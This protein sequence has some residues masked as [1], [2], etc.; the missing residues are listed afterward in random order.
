MWLAII[1]AFA[2]ILVN[3][4]MDE[5]D[6]RFDRWFN[7]VIKPNS[8]LWHWACPTVSWANKY[9]KNN[10]LRYLLSGPLVFVTDLW[11][12]LKSIFLNLIFLICLIIGGYKGNFLG[13]LGILALINIAWG[14]LFES[15]A[16]VYG[17]LSDKYI[18]TK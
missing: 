6:F 8:K 18:N 12:L 15:F 9:V 17:A 14:I 13:T 11:H 1:L 5:V 2:A 7:K 3:A 10:I 4:T 16:G